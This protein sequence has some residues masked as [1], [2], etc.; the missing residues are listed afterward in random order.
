M[1]VL[2]DYVDRARRGAVIVVMHDR[3]RCRAIVVV[4]DRGAVMHDVVRLVHDDVTDMAVAAVVA[5]AA[6]V[7]IT[8][9]AVGERGCRH[10]GGGDQDSDF[11]GEHCGLLS[12]VKCYCISR[13]W[14]LEVNG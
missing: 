8:V 1:I 7:V 9:A 6:A 3:A 14:G 10:R 13:A 5:V 2:L 12:S 4:D 11:L